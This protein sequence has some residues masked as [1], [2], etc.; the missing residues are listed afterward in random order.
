MGC[1]F[2][3]CISHPACKT[4]YYLDRVV[5]KPRGHGEQRKYHDDDGSSMNDSQTSIITYEYQELTKFINS[6]TTDMMLILFDR[7]QRLESSSTGTCKSDK[8]KPLA[9]PNRIE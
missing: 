7:V 3:T 4:E 1:C 2:G 5:E 6:H 8:T 9:I